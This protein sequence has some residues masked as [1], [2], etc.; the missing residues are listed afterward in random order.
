MDKLKPCP[1]CGHDSE[2]EF[3]H[4]ISF[5][6]LCLTCGVEGPAKKRK[7]DAIKAWN[8]RP[9]E[10]AAIREATKEAVRLLE[11][12]AMHP[13]HPGR[14]SDYECAERARQALASLRKARGE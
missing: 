9:G 14:P 6:V 4:T 7:S 8:A 11:A 5:W 10:Q 13:G 2:L 12:T 3:A 1:C